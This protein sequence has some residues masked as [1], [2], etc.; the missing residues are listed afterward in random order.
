MLAT[1]CCRL[2]SHFTSNN[3]FPPF[4]VDG[5]VAIALWLK[6]GLIIIQVQEVKAPEA[7]AQPRLSSLQ[8]RNT[9]FQLRKWTTNFRPILWRDRARDCRWG[10]RETLLRMLQ[11]KSSVTTPNVNNRLRR[12]V[13]LVNGSKSCFPFVLS[14]RCYLFL[15]ERISS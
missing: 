3:A 6:Q 12:S 9:F 10:E 5:G 8:H 4:P 14:I 13:V 2:R 15:R 11:D 1:F 7:L